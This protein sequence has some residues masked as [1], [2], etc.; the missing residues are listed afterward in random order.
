MIRRVPKDFADLDRRGLV[1]VSTEI[2]VADD[3][4]GVR[5]HEVVKQLTMELEAYWRGLRDGQ[6][7]EA[8]LR[9]EAD[10]K[11][12]RALG[13]PYQAVGEIAQGPLEDFLK[14][15]QILMDKGDVE[16]ERGVAAIFGGESRPNLLLS[17]LLDEFEA[18]QKA[19][20]AQSR[21]IR[22]ANGA[23]PSAG[24]S[25]ILYLWSKTKPS[26]ISLAAT[27]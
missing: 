22:S 21:M 26:T 24:Q 15:V 10:Q 18:I 1:R 7:A 12:A 6:S 16:N 27:L 25:T 4:R 17:G 23:T 19:S 13:L 20:L 9:Y 2:A 5:A 11:R 8:R 14:R 3:P